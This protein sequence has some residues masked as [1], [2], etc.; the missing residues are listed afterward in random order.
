MHRY[1]IIALVYV[2]NIAVLLDYLLLVLLKL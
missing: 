2:H 1:N